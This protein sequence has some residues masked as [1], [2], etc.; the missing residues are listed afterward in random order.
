M[1]VFKRFSRS[2][3]QI[4]DAGLKELAKLKQLGAHNLISTKTTNAGVAQLQKAL[5]KCNIGRNA[6]K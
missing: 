6:E 2:R 5:P 4:T 3:K 1:D